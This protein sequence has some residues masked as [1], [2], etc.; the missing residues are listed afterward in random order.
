MSLEQQIK[1]VSRA[2]AL[3]GVPY[4]Y[5]AT[6]EEAPN[7]FDCSSFIQYLFK[8]T[9]IEL[10]RSALLQAGD[11]RGKELLPN[12]EFEQGDLLFMRSSAGHYKDDLFEG[13]PIE[14]G[15][16]AIYTGNGMVIH[17]KA[18]AGGVIEQPLKEL[19]ANPNYALVYAKR[20]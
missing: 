8:D 4:K 14:I 3:V 13:R 10:P 19:T 7:F 17:A 12:S 18:D 16:V 6:P 9:G 1:I 15:H 2:E 5:G 20:F 11:P